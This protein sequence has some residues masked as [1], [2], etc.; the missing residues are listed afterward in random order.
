MRAAHDQ[1]CDVN[2]KRPPR[3]RAECCSPAGGSIL[4][5]SGNFMKWALDGASW[6]LGG[7]MGVYVL[8]W[9]PFHLFSVSD[10]VSLSGFLA[11]MI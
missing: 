2:T 8:S 11:T 5:D 9:T 7:V 1:P 10:S 6:L 4:G 3:A